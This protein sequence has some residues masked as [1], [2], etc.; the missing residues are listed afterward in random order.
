MKFTTSV[1]LNDVAESRYVSLEVEVICPWSV[2]IIRVE[3]S[4]Q[5]TESAIWVI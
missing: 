3:I 2:I 4:G 1:E 5:P